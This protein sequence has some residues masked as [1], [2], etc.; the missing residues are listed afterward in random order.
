MEDLI[1]EINSIQNYGSLE[2]KIH[3]MLWFRLLNWNEIVFTSL[4][5]TIF[6]RIVSAQL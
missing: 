4:K 3:I 2:K 6:I 5:Y 1:S